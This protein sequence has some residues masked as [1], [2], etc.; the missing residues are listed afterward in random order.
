VHKRSWKIFLNGFNFGRPIHSSCWW[1]NL[2][3]AKKT[4]DICDV[5]QRYTYG[6]YFPDWDRLGYK[7]SQALFSLFLNKQTKKK[8]EAM[9]SFWKM[10]G[11]SK[12][13]FRY[14]ASCDWW[15]YVP[16]WPTDTPSSI[17]TRHK[18]NYGTKLCNFLWS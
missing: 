3:K 13:C 2:R 17:T 15:R 16:T 7:S 14:V 8:E 5:H 10:L 6:E 18:V 4:V 1:L 12:L 11:K 9:F